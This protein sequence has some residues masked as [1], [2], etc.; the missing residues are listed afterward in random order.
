MVLFNETMR[1]T[2]RDRIAGP[3]TSWQQRTVRIL[4]VLTVLLTAYLVIGNF[5]SHRIDDDIYFVPPNPV[6]GGSYT[7]N[8]AAALIERE[9]VTHQWQPNDPWFMPD[10]LLDN[11]PNFQQGIISAV[12]RLSFELL[13]QLGRVRGSSQ[14]DPDLERAAGLLQFPGDIWIIDF[15]KS[16]M[17]TIPSED[18][19]RA[20]L[21]ALVSY[22]T[23]LAQGQ[24]VFDRRADSLAATVQRVAADLG[25]RSALI[26]AHLE[27][28]S[29]F[30]L[31]RSADDLFYQNKG[32]LYAYYLLLREIGRDFER[33]IQERNLQTVWA[34]T[35]ESL[36]QAAVLQP[37]VVLD[38][39]T[40]SA[41]FASHLASQGFYLL[42]ALVQLNEVTKVLGV[43]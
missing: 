25:S 36:R 37:T 6:A 23:R 31:N 3:A 16:L 11:T 40:D 32:R 12:G 42:R 20:A 18:Q 2:Q 28:S 17:P 39:S 19:Y 24:A 22:N 21:R 4:V 13:D 14:A 38:A 10:G 29:G 1:L 26:D 27:H 35:M 8:M 7:V 30:I 43:R 34:Q 41:L 15:S 5:A 33:V 9:V